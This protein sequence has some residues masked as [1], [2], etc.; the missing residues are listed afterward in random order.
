MGTRSGPVDQADLIESVQSFLHGDEVREGGEV[1][2]VALVRAGHERLPCGLGGIVIRR[3][4]QAG[5]LV[6]VVGLDDEPVAL[7]I[8][9]VLVSGAARRD[10]ARLPERLGR[11]D[12]VHLGGFVIA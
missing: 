12:Q 11:R 2:D 3:G 5:V 7:V 10:H 4:D 8:D 6:G 1:P 9:V